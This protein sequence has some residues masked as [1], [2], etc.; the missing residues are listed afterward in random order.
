MK[1]ILSGTILTVIACVISVLNSQA[2]TPG[3]MLGLS[4]DVSGAVSVA[5]VNPGGC[6]T[7]ICTTNIVTYSHCYTN[8]YWK[9]VCTTNAAT[10]QIQCTNTLVCETRCYTNTFPRITCTN[11]F[12]NPT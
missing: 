5:S 11:E 7:R 9:P 2:Q 1:R 10:G 6:P 3:T 8:C 12:L 4:A